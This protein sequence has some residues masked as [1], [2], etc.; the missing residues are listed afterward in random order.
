MV[1][2]KTI[3][4]KI[5]EA[6]KL[7]NLSQ[8][9]LA[10]QLFISPQAVGK[11]ERGE[12]L[13]DITILNRLAEIFGV[14]LNYFS[15]G[16]SSKEVLPDDLSIIAEHPGDVKKSAE[17]VNKDMAGWNWKEADFSG[18]ELDSVKFNS[19]DLFKASFDG[20]QLN[21]CSLK[22][23]NLIE[24]SFKQCILANCDFSMSS[25][26]GTLFMGTRFND[27]KIQKSD[28]RKTIF[29]DCSFTGVDFSYSDLSGQILDGM[30]FNQVSFNYSNLK[31]VSFK[32]ANLQD[33]SFQAPLAIT[34]KYYKTLKTICFEGATI[35][36]LTYARLKS[37][38][39]EL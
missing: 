31:E 37:L 27:V 33:V 30:S 25:L 12:S 35:D 17:L 28:L 23:S 3:G 26:F 2:A 22:T 32:G 38:G 16:F 4:N 8:A 20:S 6:R 21:N 19:S 14:D 39:V 15:E 18:I 7:K 1:L 10:Q 29:E 9:Q 34:N 36:K 24:A 13:P 11:W 5:M